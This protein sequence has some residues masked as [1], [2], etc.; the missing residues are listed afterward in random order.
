MAAG[1]LRIASSITMLQSGYATAHSDITNNARNPS[2]LEA[3]NF[4]QSWTGLW[5]KKIYTVFTEFQI[6][7][8]HELSTTWN[9]VEN[10]STSRVSKLL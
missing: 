5:L 3:T 2:R 6:S 10:Q 7:C 4:G 9:Q 8:C 1:R